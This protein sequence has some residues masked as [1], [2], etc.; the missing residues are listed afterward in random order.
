MKKSTIYG[1]IWSAWLGYW[2]S[3]LGAN[4]LTWQFWLIFVPV[5][6]FVNLESNAK[7]DGE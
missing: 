2:L 5:V 1:I 7:V 4:L 6:I 3:V